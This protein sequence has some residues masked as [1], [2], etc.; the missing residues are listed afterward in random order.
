MTAGVLAIQ[1]Q[2]EMFIEVFEKH[3]YQ[4]RDAY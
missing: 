4:C 3:I 1:D 2:M